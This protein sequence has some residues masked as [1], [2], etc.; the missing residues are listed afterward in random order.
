MRKAAY[1]DN[2]AENLGYETCP[3][4]GALKSGGE[5]DP[6][7]PEHP[8]CV[9]L[10]AS[11]SQFERDPVDWM[12]LNLKAFSGKT[13]E[14]YPSFILGVLCRMMKFVEEDGGTRQGAEFRLS[15]LEPRFK[16]IKWLLRRKGEARL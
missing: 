14:E 4:C 10:R 11:F 7:G 2:G 12:L 1:M 16:Q 6:G 5:A 13:L 15:H 9:A 3:M 8:A